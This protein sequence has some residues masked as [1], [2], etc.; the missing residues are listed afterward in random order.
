MR[1]CSTEREYREAHDINYFRDFTPSTSSSRQLSRLAPACAPTIATSSAEGLPARGNYGEGDDATPLPHL[2]ITST[3]KSL[4][5]A[6]RRRAPLSDAQPHRSESPNSRAEF[7]ST[8]AN[9]LSASVFVQSIR[10]ANPL[11]SVAGK[12]TRRSVHATSRVPRAALGVESI[13]EFV[14]S[15]FG[16]PA[17]IGSSGENRKPRVPS[18]LG[19][20][21]V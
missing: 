15:S 12:L 10:N 17:R 13:L 19:A 2:P 8:A 6:T 21:V 16:V 18:S 7:R 1:P 3:I 20:R 11:G 4:N 5:Y 9:I 14:A